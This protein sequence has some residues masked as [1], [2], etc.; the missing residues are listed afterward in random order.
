MEKYAWKA[1]IIDGKQDEYKLRHDKIWQEMKDV[2]R[3]AGIKNY[4]IWLCGTDLFGYYECDKGIDFAA[5][6]QNNSPVVAKWNEYMRDVMIMEPD[7]V[8]GAQPLL[9]KVFEFN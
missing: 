7:P 9:T 5:S 1:K 4:S 6:V 3:S 8:T 2:L